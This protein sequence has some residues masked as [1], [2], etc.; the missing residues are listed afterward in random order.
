MTFCKKNYC[1]A[2]GIDFVESQGKKGVFC[3]KKKNFSWY[4]RASDDRLTFEE[5]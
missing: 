4:P 1:V 5:L 2:G 3:R